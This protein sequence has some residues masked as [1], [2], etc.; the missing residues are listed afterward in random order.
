MANNNDSKAREL[1]IKELMAKAVNKEATIEDA[2]EVLDLFKAEKEVD[3][4][5]DH[6][7]KIAQNTLNGHRASN[8]DPLLEHVRGVAKKALN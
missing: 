4:I 3:A 7:S 5:L 1:R 6:V 8:N 2:K